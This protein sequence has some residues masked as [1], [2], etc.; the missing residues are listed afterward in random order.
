MTEYDSKNL[1]NCN[2]K[3]QMGT[4][5]F[6]LGSSILDSK[7]EDNQIMFKILDFNGFAQNVAGLQENHCTVTMFLGK[8]GDNRYIKLKCTESDS[9][10]T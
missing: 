6:T 2:V 10:I 8:E 3:I 7:R 1:R 9:L 5:Y 4:E